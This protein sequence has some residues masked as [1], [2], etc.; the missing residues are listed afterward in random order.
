MIITDCFWEHENLG[1]NTIE[2]V[3]DQSEQINPSTIQDI[4]NHHS[5]VVVKV[6]MN[7]PDINFILSDLGFTCIEVQHH[8]EKELRSF[9][10]TNIAHL[11]KDIIFEEVSDQRSLES[12]LLHIT[13]GM[14]STDRVSLDPKYGLEFGCRRY[15]NWIRATYLSEDTKLILIRYKG[16]E[17]G[18]MLLKICNHNLHNVLNGLYK[19]FQG[20]GLGLM[21]TASPAYYADSLHLPVS[22][23]TT[24]ISSNNI[25]VVKLYNR[26]QFTLAHQQYVFVKHGKEDI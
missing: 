2:I 11:T 12:T 26:L 6:P 25:P 24:A 20:R 16:E 17:I 21:M 14:F 23:I 8:L 18:F 15:K 10:F 4:V 9:D 1:G 22:K 3:V 19:P 7:R 5:Y 13:P